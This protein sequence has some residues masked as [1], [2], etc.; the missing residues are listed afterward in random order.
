MKTFDDL[1]F[2]PHP[3]MP[4][5]VR[6]TL[7]LDSGLQL[8]VVAGDTFYNDKGTYE[9]AIFKDGDFVPISTSDDVIGW[10]SPDEITT[11]LEEIQKD[12]SGFVERKVQERA[13]HRKELDLD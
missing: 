6:S 9:V 13:E 12:A 4:T 10:Q 5:G 2:S 3:N 1:E 11:L 8:S 7:H